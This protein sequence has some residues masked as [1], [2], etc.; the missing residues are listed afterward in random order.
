MVGLDIFLITFIDLS[1]L[2]ST[3]SWLF[4]ALIVIPKALEL[5]T[6]FDD[7]IFADD[8]NTLSSNKG[9]IVFLIK[10]LFLFCLLELLIE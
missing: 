7:A 3:I 6:A 9:A 2:I 10:R 5:L 1:G 4:I 8:N